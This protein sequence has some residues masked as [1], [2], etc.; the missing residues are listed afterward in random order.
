LSLLLICHLHGWIIAYFLGK[1]SSVLVLQRTFPIRNRIWESAWHYSGL[2]KTV[3]R[4][5][6]FNPTNQQK[7]LGLAKRIEKHLE[8]DLEAY[9][10]EFY[11][12]WARM[13]KLGRKD[14][15]EQLRSCGCVNCKL[16]TRR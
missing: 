8:K 11:R 4:H 6:W 2:V 16:K 15:L 3:N 13:D 14:V 9:R 12:F 10:A 7:A 5:K 1:V